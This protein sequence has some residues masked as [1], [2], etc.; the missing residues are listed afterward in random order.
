MKKKHLTKKYNIL[1]TISF[2]Q[3]YLLFFENAVALMQFNS[4]RTHN[5]HCSIKDF[6]CGRFVHQRSS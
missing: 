2:N 4:E 3:S 6:L 5:N 1:S